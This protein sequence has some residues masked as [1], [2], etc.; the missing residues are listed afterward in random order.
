MNYL[1]MLEYLLSTEA[2]LIQK[3]QP[4]LNN[5]LDPDKGPRVTT[6]ICD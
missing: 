4:S 2:L 3:L 1:D 6:N 5:Q